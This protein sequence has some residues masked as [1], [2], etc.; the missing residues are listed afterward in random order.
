LADAKTIYTLPWSPPE[1]NQKMR[2]SRY[3]TL[4]AVA[5]TKIDAS[6]FKT[7]THDDYFLP[8]M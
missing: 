1:N 7:A 5:V 4:L 8:M 2:R 6:S 3:F